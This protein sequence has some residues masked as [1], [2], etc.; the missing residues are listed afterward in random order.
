ADSIVSGA[1]DLLTRDYRRQLVR[2]AAAIT[3][4]APGARAPNL[5]TGYAFHYDPQRASGASINLD[6]PEYP[7]IVGAPLSPYTGAVAAGMPPLPAAHLARLRAW[8][9]RLLA[10]S[11]THAGYLNW[12]TGYG[13]KRW[14]SAEYWAFAQQGLVAIATAPSFWL[15]P[16]EG[17]WAKAIF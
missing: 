3:R 7:S 10:G 9:L 12:D 2:F 14:Q 1:P 16:R 6:A 15:L 17:A 11:W 4:P 8:V 5:G 13:R